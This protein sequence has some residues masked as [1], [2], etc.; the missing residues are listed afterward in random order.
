MLQ[1]EPAAAPASAAPPIRPWP[2]G[3]LPCQPI[4]SVVLVGEASESFTWTLDGLR[5]GSDAAVGRCLGVEGINTAVDRTQQALLERGFVTSRILVQAQDLS[6]GVLALTFLP[7]RI[8]AIRFATPQESRAT[9]INAVPAGSGDILNLRDIEQALENFKRVPT[10][11]A[12]VKVEPADA[13]GQSDLVISWRQAYPFRLALSVDD[14]GTKATGRYQGSATLSY[15]HWWTLNDLFYVT[16][17]HDLGGGDKGER[18]TQ[19]HTV[20]YSVPWDYWLLGLTQWSSRYYQSVAGFSQDYIYR[21]TSDNAEVKLSWLFYRDVSRKSTFSLKGWMRRSN[22]FI[23]DTEVETQRRATGG[24]ELSLAD[25]EF[26]GPATL[27]VSVAYKR[28]TAAFNAIPAPEEPFGE[29]TSRLRIA[30]VDANLQVPFTLAR[31]ALRYSANWRAQWNGTPLPSQ[32]RFAIGGRYT[33]RGFDGGSSLLAERG[34]LMRND[35]SVGLGDSGHEVYLGLDYGQ[36]RGPSSAFLGGRHL[37][38]TALGLRGVIQKLNKLSYD[39]FVGKPISRPATF[40]TAAVTAGFNLA[41]S[42]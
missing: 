22:N 17:N 13:P 40:R 38:G 4:R 20:H 12:D 21:G 10:V 24:W 32:D 37:A 26:I 18:G 25:R 31:Q 41:A 15:D 27:D 33:V 3:E 9:A 6:G 7:G 42:F 16:L 29:G 35:L 23:D 30:T 1:P 14:S 8:R 11:Q 36:V 2:V 34:W 28:G 5:S 19:G 39:V